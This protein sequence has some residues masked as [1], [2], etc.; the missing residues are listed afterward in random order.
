MTPAPEFQLIRPGLFF[1]Q[2]YD[3]AV[4]IDLCCC[5]LET[6]GGI[7]FCDPVPLDSLA[8]EELIAARTPRAILLT[9]AN[10]E[11]NAALLARRYGIE[12]WAPSAARG[13]VQATRWYAEGPILDGDLE[14]IALE[15]FAPGETAL[16]WQDVLL[17]GDALINLP[18]Y[19]FTMLPRK[20]CE[21]AEAAANSL[22]KLLRFPVE[23]LTF[24]HG[25]P[26]V[27]QTRQR[28]ADLIAQSSV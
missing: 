13:Q 25:L 24:A 19:G 1:W 23:T 22:K 28:L 17:L 9:N 10:H 12:I 5:A 11:R 26:L 7:L 3:P 27:S 8:E 2:A 15:G 20:Y 18:P 4:K 16:W 14:A 21:D 6:A